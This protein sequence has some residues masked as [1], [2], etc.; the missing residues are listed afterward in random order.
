L[1]AARSQ[2]I[3][4]DGEVAVVFDLAEN[5][6]GAGEGAAVHKLAPGL[7]LEFQAANDQ[8]AGASPRVRFFPDGSASR[9]R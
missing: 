5:A 1:R 9:M 4:E 3:A 7:T 8:G 6:Y 2:A